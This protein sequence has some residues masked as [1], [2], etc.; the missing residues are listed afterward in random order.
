M[1]GSSTEEQTN[2]VNKIVSNVSKKAAID[3]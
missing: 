3:K 2:N 1:S